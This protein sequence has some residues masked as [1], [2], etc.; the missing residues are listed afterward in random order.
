MDEKKKVEYVKPQILDL[1][2]VTPALGG[3]CSTLGTNPTGKLACGATGSWVAICA[4]GT[5]GG[6]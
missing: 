1:G 4:T 3:T 2:A 6:S 5:V